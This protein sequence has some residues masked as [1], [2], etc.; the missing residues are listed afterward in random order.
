[1]LFR[2]RGNF[3]GR[4]GELSWT[5]Q[6]DDSALVALK[7]LIDQELPGT[8]ILSHRAESEEEGA[9]SR[10]VSRIVIRNGGDQNW[11]GVGVDSD[12]EIAAMKALLDAVNRAW[13]DKHFAQEPKP[14]SLSGI[15]E[16]EGE[17]SI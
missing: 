16:E 10:S 12:I 2:S 9:R 3:F 6:G 1:M 4:E 17:G 13:I 11:T 7:E 14:F 8:E 5:R 15:A